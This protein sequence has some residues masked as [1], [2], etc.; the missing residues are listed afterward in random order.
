MLEIDQTTFDQNLLLTQAYCDEQ[1]K[2]THKNFA[3]ILRSFNPVYD[4]KQIYSYA[5][6]SFSGQFDE[7]YQFLTKCNLNPLENS[8]YN[9]LF[10]KQMNHKNDK[11]VTPNQMEFIGQILQ[12][13]IDCAIMDGVSRFESRGF[14]D[15]YDCP[16]IDT[17]FYIENKKNKRVLFA[18]IPEPFVINVDQCIDINA[19][20]VLS[21]FRVG[22]TESDNWHNENLGEI[23]QTT[24]K[25]NENPPSVFDQLKK[26]FS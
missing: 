21:W 16:P 4:G 19:L 20:G 3:S 24:L 11:I 22:R 8:L 23:K 13:E 5:L 17:W 15:Y 1:L 14:L 9:E 26:M 7:E 2:N 12:V 10:E 25:E 6:E 18:W